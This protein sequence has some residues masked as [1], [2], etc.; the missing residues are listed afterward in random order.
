M[1][2]LLP[3]IAAT[4]IAEERRETGSV[5]DGMGATSPGWECLRAQEMPADSQG[6]WRAY[7]V[8]STVGFWCFS[9]FS[10]YSTHCRAYYYYSC[11]TGARRRSLI[12]S[13]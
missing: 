2:I 5:T 8:T 4:G 7:H 11:L 13:T 9:P 3:E 1:T 10:T 6:S 12:V